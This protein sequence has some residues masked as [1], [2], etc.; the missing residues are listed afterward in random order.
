[1]SS[2]VAP[3]LAAANKRIGNI[4]RKS[5]PAASN[6]INEDMLVIDEE[7]RLFTEIRNISN[8]LQTQYQHSDYTAALAL[9]ANLSAAVEAFFDKV[10][11]MDDD[12]TVRS[13][14]LNLLAELK[15]MFDR[16]ANLALVG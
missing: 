5:E 12:L 15:G 14:R 1:M 9:L 10:M 8:E 6:T 11:V 16:V 2:E 3:Q 4:L 13:N 7:V